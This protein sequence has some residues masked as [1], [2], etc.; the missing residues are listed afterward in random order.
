MSTVLRRPYLGPKV[1]GLRAREI[2]RDKLLALA[3]ASTPDEFLNVLKTTEYAV[4]VDK[5]TRETL[6]ELRR[7]LVKIYLERLKSLFLFLSGDAEAKT[8]VLASVKYFEYD[9]IRN[10]AAAVKAGKNPEDFVLWEPLEFTGRRHVIAGILGSK[11]ISEIGDRLRQMGHPAHKAFELAGKY[12]EDKLYIFIDRQWLEDLYT[13]MP[14]SIRVP[15][16]ADR[17]IHKF[18]TDVTEYLNALIA[19]RARLWGLSAEELNE[20]LIGTPT[21]VVLAALKEA[22]AR[23]LEMAEATTWGKILVELVAEAPT[24]ENIAVTLDN[25]YPAYM[26]RLADTYASTFTEFSLGAL[27]A[28]AEYM[29]AEVLAIIRAAAMIVEGVPVERRKRVFEA[30]VRH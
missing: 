15:V 30:L 26:R 25:L 12:G 14:R 22:P 24:L 7:E 19:I 23:F 9:N 6:N 17:S 21:P 28:L 16:G 10:V 8:V 3:Y 20:L 13:Y 29:R 5:L 4:T 2:P 11:S 1:R 18:L 27:A